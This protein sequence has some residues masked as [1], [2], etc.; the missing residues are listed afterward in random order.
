MAIKKYIASLDN[1]ITNAKGVDKPTRA[2]GSNMGAADILETFSIYGLA[3]TSSVELSRILIQFPVDKI[4]SDR[5]AGTIPEPGKVNFFL[6]MFNAKHSEQLPENFTVNV[7]AVSSSWQEGSGLDMEGYTDKTKDNIKGSNWKNANNNFV[8]A[9]L[10]DAIDTT[11]VAI[12][13]A[14]TMTVP[15]A[16]GGDATAHVFNFVD[17]AVAGAG[18]NNFGIALDT[19]NTPAKAATAVVDAINGT[20]NSAVGYN[21]GAN[22]TVLTAGTIGLT[23]AITADETTKITLTMDDTGT[24]GNVA[25]VL[26]AN[27]GFEPASDLLKIAAFTVGD[28]AWTTVGGDYH[29]SPYVSGSTMPNY[30]FTFVNGDED[31]LLDVSSAVEEWLANNKPNYGFGV[32]LTSSLEGYVSN[33]SGDTVGA[34]LHNPSGQQK[35][36]YTK[37][38][39]SRSSEFFF[40]QPVIEARWD[41]RVMDDRG[42]F[43][44]SSSIAPA[45]DNLNNLYLYNYIRGRLVDIPSAETL[46]VNLYAS[47]NGAPSGP[48][49]T[50]LTAS[51]ANTGVYKVT[52]SINTTSSIIHDVWSG[53]VGGEYKTGTISVKNFNNTSVLNSDDYTQF[54]T[55]IINLKSKYAKDEI[56]R[57]RVFTRPR[58]YSPTIYTVASTEMQHVIIPSASFEIVRIADNNKMINNSTGSSTNHTYMSYDSSGSYFDLDMKL[59][60]PGYMYG[61][62][63]LFYC[64]NGWRKQEE[65]FNFRVENN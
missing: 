29:T 21:G 40:K 48:R 53:S 5:A 44:S 57:F 38:F 50:V 47:S 52:G 7:L 39:F 6:R 60:E 8:Q 24:A 62:K 10:I 46:A 25:N 14:F 31:L 17:T 55:K 22:G 16:A 32:F 11:G 18:S 27:T 23:A 61:I 15:A 37:R 13:D 34:I 51:K 59:L 43:Y 9:T 19:A 33:S 30:T 20:V 1:T 42:N 4:S 41:S 58:N 65:T 3:T 54:T 36:C 28:G 12:N 64:S 45:L 2:T 26:A 63:F 49:L 56:A 35:S